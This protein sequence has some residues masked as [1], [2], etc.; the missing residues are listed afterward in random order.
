M[1]SEKIKILRI[2]KDKIFGVILDD[3]GFVGGK[4]VLKNTHQPIANLLGI[5][6]SLAP[7]ACIR[8][9]GPVTDY[10]TT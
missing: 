6:P 7:K 9:L 4:L 3:P 1:F 2:H 10:Y 5:N 8:A